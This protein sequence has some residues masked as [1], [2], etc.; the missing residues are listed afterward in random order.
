MAFCHLGRNYAWQLALPCR[1]HQEGGGHVCMYIER[2]RHYF[3][4][5]KGAWAAG[6]DCKR[7]IN[8]RWAPCL[9][10]RTLRAYRAALLASWLPGLWC[11]WDAHGLG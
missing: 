7:C 3:P 6:M 11:K 1:L 4:L 10:Q 8:L 9:F 2:K 5:C